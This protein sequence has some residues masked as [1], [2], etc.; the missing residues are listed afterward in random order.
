MVKLT[1][2]MATV[3]TIGMATSLLFVSLIA[4]NKKQ[5]SWFVCTVETVTM[6]ILVVLDSLGVASMFY[7]KP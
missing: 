5:K 3:A 4:R 2:S 7:Q 6:L 1:I